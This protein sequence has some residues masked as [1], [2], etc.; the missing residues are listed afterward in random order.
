MIPT[1]P[2]QSYGSSTNTE[3]LV[4]HLYPFVQFQCIVVYLNSHTLGEVDL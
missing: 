1:L 4:W 2:S 3:D